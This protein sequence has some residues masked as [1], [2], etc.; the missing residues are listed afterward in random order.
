[1]PTDRQADQAWIERDRRENLRRANLTPDQR[2]CDDYLI[3]A[4]KVL[5]RIPPAPIDS[6]ARA[7]LRAWMDVA[8]LSAERVDA[9][10][11][12]HGFVRPDGTVPRIS[13]DR[14]PWWR[15]LA[16]AEG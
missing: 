16:P 7:A 5:D 1:M 6:S 8:P 4:C 3:D 10:C 11:D 9:L 14:T 2:V 12:P 15:N 13:Q